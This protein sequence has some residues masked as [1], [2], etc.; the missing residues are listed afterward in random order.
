MGNKRLYI[1]FTKRRW[2]KIA[3]AF[4]GVLLIAQIAQVVY[5]IGYKVVLDDMTGEV[6][7]SGFVWNSDDF[8]MAIILYVPAFLV[9]YGG[10]IFY[11]VR[12]KE[13]LPSRP[14]FYGKNK[15]VATCFT[16]VYFIVLL[17]F[18][19]LSLLISPDY[20]Y[21]HGNQ[22]A[23]YIFGGSMITLIVGVPVNLVGL[24]LWYLNHGVQDDSLN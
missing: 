18:F 16:V 2:D 1:G 7:S 12:D 14:M 4:L 6:V 21:Y 24:L 15:V 17:A 3:L 11:L 22:A 13:I 9:A 10:L 19:I 5:A 20:E 23:M 8:I